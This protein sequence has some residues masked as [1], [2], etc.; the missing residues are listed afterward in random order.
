[1]VFCLVLDVQLFVRVCL[2]KVVA[3]SS[4]HA[5]TSADLSAFIEDTVLDV[6]S[7]AVW[8]LEDKSAENEDDEA[9]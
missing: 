7:A 4:A 3:N 2:R 1:M 5:V 6:E 8:L 9:L